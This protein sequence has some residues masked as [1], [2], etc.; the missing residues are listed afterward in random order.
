MRQPLVLCRRGHDIT[1]Q[2]H[3]P[4]GW[5]CDECGCGCVIRGGES[6]AEAQKPERASRPGP[7]VEPKTLLA[8]VAARKEL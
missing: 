7:R 6:A 1:S 4:G 8:V 5:W 2:W 3:K